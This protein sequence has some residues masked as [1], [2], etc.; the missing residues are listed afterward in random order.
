M[1]K[2]HLNIQTEAFSEKY[3]GLPTTV[4]K[5]ISDAFEYITESARSSVNG[6]AKKNL[7]YPGKEVL[8]KSVIQAKP[9]HGMSYFLLSKGS[10]TKFTS[11][12]GR[13]LVKW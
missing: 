5:L 3:L 4:G 2:Q 9:I 7:S 10:C 8:I 11:V 6:W 13:F 1:V 12:M